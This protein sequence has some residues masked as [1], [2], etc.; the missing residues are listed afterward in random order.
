MGRINAGSDRRLEDLIRALP[1]FLIHVRVLLFPTP[2]A[3]DESVEVSSPHSLLFFPASSTRKRPIS[4]RRCNEYN[5]APAP[6]IA[7]TALA[8]ETSVVEPWL[9]PI[10]DVM[11]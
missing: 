5:N 6:A 3:P 7:A 1:S 10:E 9:L 4:L 11:P 2:S 8:P